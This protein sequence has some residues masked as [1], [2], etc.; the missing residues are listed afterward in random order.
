MLLGCIY[1]I[2]FNGSKTFQWK[3]LSPLMV[4]LGD[5]KVVFLLRHFNIDL[6]KN[7]IDTHTCY[8]GHDNFKF[9]HLTRITT[10][11]KT[12]I[13]NIFSN[14]QNISQGKSG[15]LTT[16]ISDHLAQFL[17]I[18]LDVC[19]VPRKINLYE[20]DNRNF[21]KDIFFLDLISI[22]YIKHTYWQIYAIK[23][24]YT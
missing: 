13:D 6:M 15:N 24:S 9:I 8:F 17:I 16:S 7:D 18:A 2:S 23:K 14:S 12:L 10:H 1:T 4:K 5:K 11:S 19:Y 22:G 20:R 21:D 3:L